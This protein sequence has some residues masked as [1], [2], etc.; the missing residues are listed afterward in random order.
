MSKLLQTLSIAGF[1]CFSLLT[2][3]VHAQQS[4]DKLGEFDEIIIKRKGNNDGKVT[5][6]IKNGEVLVDGKKVDQYNSPDISVFKRKVT[7]MDG[8]SLGMGGSMNGFNFFN[9]NDD[10]E[11]GDGPQVFNIKPNKA[12]LGVITEKEEAAG[13]T[14]KTVSPNSPAAKAG[15]K[16]GDVITRVDAKKIA[17]PKELYETIGTYDPGD[18]ITITYTRNKKE[19]QATVTLDERKEQGGMEL[20]MPSPDRNRGGFFNFQGPE[21]NDNF[22][23]RRGGSNLRLGLQVEDTE[24]G[25]GAKVSDVEEGSAA[26]KAGFQNDDIVTEFGGTAVKSARDVANAYRFN[27][28]KANITAKVIRNGASQT[29]EVKIPKKINKVNL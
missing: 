17:E 29:L 22:S 14:V 10:A 9:D 5:V 4:K 26:E 16:A 24:D 23:F 27:Q 18:K 15:I 21:M 7:P 20:L 28:Q 3:T 19:T 25:K 11:E 13:V 2:T 1:T 6:E 8:N 12:L